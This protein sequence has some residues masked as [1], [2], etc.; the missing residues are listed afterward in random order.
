MIYEKIGSREMIDLRGSSRRARGRLV[1]KCILVATCEPRTNP[2]W[3][4]IRCQLARP[5]PRHRR[6]TPPYATN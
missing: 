2:S 4:P 3:T 1:W 5:L 6:R